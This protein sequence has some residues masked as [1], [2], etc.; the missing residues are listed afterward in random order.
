MTTTRPSSFVYK[1][2]QDIDAICQPIFQK[3]N[4]NYFH[5]FRAYKDGS[6]V[7][8]YS[9]TD[10]HDY[11]YDSG[12][13]TQTPIIEDNLSFKKAN[14]CLWQGIV[15]DHVMHDAS[16]LFNLGNPLSIVFTHKDCFE[17]FAFAGDQSNDQLINAYFNNID[18]LLRYTHEFRDKAAGIILEAESNKFTLATQ[19]Q[20][21]SLQLLNGSVPN[22]PLIIQGNNRVAQ[23]TPREVSIAQHLLYGYTVNDLADK[24]SRSPRTIESHMN[25][26]KDKLKCKRRSDLQYVLMQQSQKLFH[27]VGTL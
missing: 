8:L 4:L 16:S 26:L 2:Q 13:K 5:Y 1:A 17:C 25:S 6:A 10:W 3:L 22:K 9:R 23:L 21:D 7:T 19:Q 15:D 27:Y 11:F 14:I 24:L 18:L 12:F 20:A